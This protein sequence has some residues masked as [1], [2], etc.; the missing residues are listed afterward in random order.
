MMLVV[1]KGTKKVIKEG[2]GTLLKLPGANKRKN[3][4]I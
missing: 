4:G 1:E 3:S 2:F